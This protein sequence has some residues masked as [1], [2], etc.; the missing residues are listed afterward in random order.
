MI[1]H[2]LSTCCDRLDKSVSRRGWQLSESGSTLVSK[3][4]HLYTT[5]A[6]SLPITK[7][8]NGN[9]IVP[10]IL[11]KPSSSTTNEQLFSTERKRHISLSSTFCLVLT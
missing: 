1:G 9:D 6:L 7:A 2:S 11:P 10:S 5:H 8:Y 4:S 3:I